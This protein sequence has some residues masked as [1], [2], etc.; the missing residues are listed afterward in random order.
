MKLFVSSLATLPAFV[1]AVAC[2][3]GVAR[4]QTAPDLSSGG[5]APPPAIEPEP[6]ET[7]PSATERELERAERE[8][9]GR[10]LSFVW[11]NGDVGYQVLGLRTF[12]D[13]DLVDGTVVPSTAHGLSVGGGL[14]VRL[15]FLTVGARFRFGTFE[16]YQAWSLGAEGSFRIPLGDLEPY[17]SLGGG[18]VSVGGFERLEPL[19]AAGLTASDLA[20]RGFY[21]RGGAGIDYFLGRSF[22]VGANLSG[23]LLFLSRPAL[24]GTNDGGLYSSDG[25][26]VGGAAT[27]M[28]TAGLHF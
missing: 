8:D 11:L 13:G 4:A 10:G 28:A 21:V 17:F 16:R 12:H 26:S 22:S 15:I 27:L 25:S 23:D 5:L 3:S 9:A 14:G 1:A 18:Y 6:A 19:S 20:I 24:G 7:S 2:L